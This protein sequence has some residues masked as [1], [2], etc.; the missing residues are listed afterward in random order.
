MGV[1]RVSDE[2]F[3]GRE[4]WK[5]PVLRD[6]IIAEALLHPRERGRMGLPEVTTWSCPSSS[7]STCSTPGDLPGRLPAQGRLEEGSARRAGLLH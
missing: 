4:Q 3:L 2:Q 5:S 7:S 1:A 6:E